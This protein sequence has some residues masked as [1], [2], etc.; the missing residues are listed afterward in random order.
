MASKEIKALIQDSVHRVESGTGLVVSSGET[1]REIVSGSVSVAAIVAEIAQA[2]GEQANGIS[3]V[4]TALSQMD[5]ITQRNAAHTE[6]LSAMA[7]D[8]SQQAAH[9]QKVSGR[10]KLGETAGRT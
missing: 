6:E 2:S 9:M 8:L 1:L 7:Q 5:G 4:G 3:Q 10:F